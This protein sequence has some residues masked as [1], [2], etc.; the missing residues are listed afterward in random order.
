MLGKKKPS[1]NVMNNIDFGFEMAQKISGADIGQTVVVKNKAVL[2][3]EAIE[4]T[5]EAIRRG[6]ALR[7]RRWDRL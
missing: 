3:V 1:K 4:G 6:G 7:D 5:D 2:A